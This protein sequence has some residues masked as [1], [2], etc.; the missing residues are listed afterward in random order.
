[1]VKAPDR[2][3]LITRIIKH[4]VQR[5]ILDPNAFIDQLYIHIQHDSYQALE[6]T[7]AELE[8]NK[9]ELDAEYNIDL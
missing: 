3:E 6:Y 2:A 4:N 7:L 1:M 9:A 8:Y 5:G